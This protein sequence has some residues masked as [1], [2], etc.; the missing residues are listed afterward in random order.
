[1]SAPLS[2]PVRVSEHCTKLYLAAL[3]EQVTRFTHY[4]YAIHDKPVVDNL[5]KHVE[6]TREHESEAVTSLCYF[7]Q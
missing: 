4:V 2:V 5:V 1:M 6:G 3:S 7:H